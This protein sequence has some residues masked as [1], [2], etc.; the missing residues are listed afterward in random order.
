MQAQ[1]ERTLANSCASN[2]VAVRA[3]GRQHSRR[4]ACHA[5]HPRQD[6][7]RRSAAHG[8]P[9]R[10]PMWSCGGSSSS[11]VVKLK[12][13]PEALRPCRAVAGLANTEY[14]RLV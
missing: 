8:S 9:C 1:P 14:N 12:P 10:L 5:G 7:A 6:R 13:A 3:A 4:K 11:I 2:R